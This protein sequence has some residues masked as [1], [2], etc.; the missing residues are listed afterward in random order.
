MEVATAEGSACQYGLARAIFMKR[1]TRPGA[2]PD[3]PRHEFR[4]DP[5]AKAAIRSGR[6]GRSGPNRL[7]ERELGRY[8]TPRAPIGLRSLIAGPLTTVPFR[9]KRDP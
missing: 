5:R 4:R 3:E 6:A 1:T 8:Y 7:G 9:S 2:N